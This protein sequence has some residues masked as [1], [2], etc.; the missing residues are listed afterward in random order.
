MNKI[1]SESEKVMNKTSEELLVK[2]T[3]SLLADLKQK[4]MQVY[5]LEEKAFQALSDVG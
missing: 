3:A 4:I 1:N 5:Q 2:D